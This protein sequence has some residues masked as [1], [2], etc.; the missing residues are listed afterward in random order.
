M[1][2]YSIH[3]DVLFDPQIKQFV[4]NV[5]LT[6]DTV[7]GCIVKVDERTE[8]L[9]ETIPEPHIDLRGKIVVPGF[10]DAHTHIFLH[11]YE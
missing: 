9:P 8:A 3:T 10:V 6:V 4:H 1:P 5:S 7:S 2:E 11:S